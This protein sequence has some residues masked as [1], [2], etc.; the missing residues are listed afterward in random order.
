[1]YKLILSFYIAILSTNL[2]AG[3]YDE[4]IQKAMKECDIERSM[5]QSSYHSNGNACERVQ[6][7]IELQKSE[8]YQNQNVN[9]HVQDKNE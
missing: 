6:Q 8:N 5:N 4:Q 1:M 3:T 2:I 9:I 7:L